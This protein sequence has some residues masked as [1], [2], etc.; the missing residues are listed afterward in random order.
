MNSDTD[1]GAHVYVYEQIHMHQCPSG[2]IYTCTVLKKGWC[3]MFTQVVC[4]TMH[5][6]YI[7]SMYNG[8]SKQ[9]AF[10]F[11]VAVPQCCYALPTHPLPLPR[12]QT[13]AF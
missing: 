4:I 10:S 8:G 3:G 1:A 11:I 6:N 13:H 12:T 7:H 9:M 5:V 2:V